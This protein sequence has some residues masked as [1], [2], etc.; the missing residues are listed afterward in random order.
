MQKT[1]AQE[2]SLEGTGLH[3]GKKAHLRFLPSESNK[4]IIFKRVDVSPAKS[5]PINDFEFT[6]H[7][8]RTAIAKNG[9]EV[10][11]VEHLMAALWA[12]SID[13]ITIEIDTEELPGLDG[14][15]DG[16]YKALKS[17]G[18]TEQ[19]TP[20]KI[21][22]IKEPLWYDKKE[23]FIGIFPG[24]NFKISYLL[25]V[26]SPAIG[27]QALSIELD[28]ES[29]AKEIAPA[30]T[31]CLRE[32]AEMLIKMGFGKGADTKNTLVMDKNGPIDNVLR[33]P[34]EPV[35]HKILDLIGDLYLVGCPI[36]CRVIAI[37]SGHDLNIEIVKMLKKRS[38]HNEDFIRH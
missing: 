13:N 36:E 3:S 10:H 32:E 14:S 30:R 34:D 28:G 31:F 22:K 29:F 7:K 35:R 17:L 1:I 21:L 24:R 11:T 4:G 20:R 27:R 23:A 8:R 12:L 19:D 15:A 9:V 16:Y 6:E 37:G 18:V 38:I 25:D 2:T 26:P 33:F 5:I